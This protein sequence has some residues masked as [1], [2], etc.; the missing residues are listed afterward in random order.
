MVDQRMHGSGT[1]LVNIKDG[2]QIELEHNANGSGK[3]NCHIFVIGDSQM[4]IL[5]WQLESVQ[6]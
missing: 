3:V 5:G 2:V 4:N 1:R 6:Y